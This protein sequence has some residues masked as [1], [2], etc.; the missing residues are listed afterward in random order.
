L[1]NKKQL[2]NEFLDS[3]FEG[4]LKPLHSRNARRI[5]E[6]FNQYKVY[7]YITT[8]D[9]EIEFGKQGLSINKK[10]INGWLLSLQEADLIFKL[11][12]RGKPVISNYEYRYTFD[13]WQ[14]TKTGLMVSQKL[15]FFKETNDLILPRL[16]ELTPSKI[17]EIEDLYM[18]SKLLITLFNHGGSLSYTDLRK[19]LAINRE[20][21]AVYS[22]PDAS[23][24]EKPLFEVIVK[25]PSLKAK[26]FK[27][28]GW[29]L[30][31]DLSF[32]L[33]EEG[34]RI[35]ADIASKE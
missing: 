33:T 3:L 12:E 13:L 24:S 34:L 5:F 10:E 19:E 14:L 25:P 1:E 27:V 31:Q 21:L 35:A 16:T 29:I 20:K 23:Y 15:L 9:I 30:E 17:R 32:K 2:S 8:H 22:W 4:I 18:T 26:V 7:N 6:V 11:N 28:F